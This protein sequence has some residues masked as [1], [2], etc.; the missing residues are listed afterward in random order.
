MS[1]AYR[2]NANWLALTD[3]FEQGRYLPML[4]SDEL[5]SNY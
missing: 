2:S 1:R 3:K 5:S 4:I